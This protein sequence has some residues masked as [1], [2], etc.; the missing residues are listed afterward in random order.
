MPVLALDL[1]KNA[2]EKFSTDARLIIG[3]AR[4]YESLNDL[5]NSVAMYKKVLS[6]DASNIEALASLGAH[7]FYSDQPELSIRYYRRLIQVNLEIIC[8]YK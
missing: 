3:M 2:S 4:I 6:L 8:S 7:F 5:E 1:L